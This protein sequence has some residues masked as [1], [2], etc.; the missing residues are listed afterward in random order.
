MS[1]IGKLI[2][3]EGPDC[4]GKS[5]I[6]EKLKIALPVIYSEEQFLYTREPGSKFGHNNESEKIREEVLSNPN[7][8][9]REQAELFAK[10]RYLH[11][12]DIVKAL[13]AGKNVITDRYLYSSIIY[14]GMDLG[15]EEVL[16]INQDTLDLLEEN[17]I[18]IH[19]IAF[20]ISE[21]TYDA[22]MNNRETQD[23][24][25]NVERAKILDR[26]YYFNHIKK[27]N[28]D[29]VLADN[30]YTVNAN[31]LSSQTFINTLNIINRI[32]K[33]EK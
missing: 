3:F 12:L 2:A 1:K 31:G 21:E 29:S 15:F 22:R 32:L 13:K 19:T 27:Y 5:T 14:Q 10:S 6:I 11:T 4:A 28:I 23:A 8:T 7:L 20:N 25:E 17:N 18:D 16:R 24:L 33:E 30:V 26:I 9:A